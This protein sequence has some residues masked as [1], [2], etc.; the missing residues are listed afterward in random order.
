M[1]LI[2][3]N[4][5]DSTKSVIRKIREMTS[6][7]LSAITKMQISET[8]SILSDLEFDIGLSLLICKICK[9]LR[10]PASITVFLTFKDELY[11][12]MYQCS[13]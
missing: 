12:C 2:Q 3:S 11:D 10:I 13:P 1:H 9:E 4:L 7:K 8:Y 5:E 6:L